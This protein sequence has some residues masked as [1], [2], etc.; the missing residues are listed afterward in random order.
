MTR[1]ALGAGFRSLQPGRLWSLAD[2]INTKSVAILCALG[3]QLN[4][5]DLIWRS[6]EPLSPEE[7]K[8]AL[9]WLD[10]AE[11]AA[12]DFEMKGARERIRLARRK[13]ERDFLDSEIA[14]EFRVLKETIDF[15][16]K[17]QLIWRYPNDRRPVLETWQHDWA[18]T[19]AK[20][21]SAAEDVWAGV[22]LWGLHHSTAAVFHFMRALEHGLRALAADLG[23]TFDVQQ[24]H[25]ILDQIESQIQSQGKS[26]TKGAAKNERLRFLSEAAKEFRFFKDGW[27]NYVS[28][29]RDPYDDHQARS[30]MDHVRS[31]MNGLSSQLTE[32]PAP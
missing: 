14:T 15:E 17:G 1:P 16:L 27:R 8:V 19:L 5:V 25:N 32:Q 13:V 24:W 4:H 7:K 31:F 3:G 20:F 23:L 30:V 2:V 26:L 29:G 12:I 21:P 18:P 9:G 22:D 6:D 11:K 10:L 28:H